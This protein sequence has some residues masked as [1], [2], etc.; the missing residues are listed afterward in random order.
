MKRFISIILCFISLSIWSQ[1]EELFKAAN[2]LYNEG[3]Y[4]ESIDKYEAIISA[5]QHSAAL[6]FNLA[7]AHYKLN[8]IAPSIFYYEKALQLSP[9]D[10]DI[11]N[12]A[13][14]AR[15]MTIDAIETVPEV[16][17]SK[18]VKNMVN[19]LSF[20]EWAK[21]AV[22]TAI[23][24]VILFLVY[25]FSYTSAKK[26]IAFVI[27]IISILVTCIS[28]T[29]AFQKYSLDQNDNPAIVFV[30]E[31]RV[32]TEP[33]QRSEEAFRLHEGTKV[34]VLDT[35]SDWKQIKIT[36][37]TTGWVRKEDIKLLNTF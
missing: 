8:N 17:F 3:K 20:D 30:Q 10:K 16:G 13:G 2:T 9:N 19:M 37:G 14:F 32:K 28:V 15:N 24:F 29:L 31:S 36:D 6:Y 1:N 33:N 23:L 7:N 26:R 4:A 12:N 27:S 18:I 5:N 22:T 35:V 25:H 21:L 34:Q 11:Q